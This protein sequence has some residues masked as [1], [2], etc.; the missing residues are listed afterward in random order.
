MKK[1]ILALLVL[2]MIAILSVACGGQEA[3]NEGDGP[4]KVNIGTLPWVGYGPWYI[5][6]EKGL[7]AEHGLDIGLTNFTAD[8]ELN[9]AFASGELDAANVATHTS[10]RFQDSGLD[11]TT[12]LIEDVS[13]EADAIVADQSVQSIEDLE[14][15]EVGFESGATTDLLL[16][17][18][19]MQN[20]LNTEDIRPV[21]LPSSDVGNALIAGRIGAGVTYEP[22]L[23]QALAEDSELQVI[24]TAAENPGLV[25]DVLVV[26]NDIAEEQPELVKKM[27]RTWNDAVQ[28]YNENTEEGQ[29]IIGENVGIED[30]DTL[31][32]IFEGV[33]LYSLEENSEQ[34][35]GSFQDTMVSIEEVLQEQGELEGEV[36]PLERL[37]TSFVEELS[38]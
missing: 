34:L 20:G 12:V 13:L 18:A 22:Y 11:F 23:S 29:R 31:T 17:Y 21:Q 2:P 4:T 1:N 25:S 30:P 36:D 14:G 6:V 9:S 19:L 3:S 16:N 8:K 5:A 27:L 26:Q 10:I 38:Q 28:Y 15:K 35:E 7:D 37:D 33:E 32:T 24:Y